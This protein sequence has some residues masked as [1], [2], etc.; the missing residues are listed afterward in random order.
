MKP[1]KYVYM[2]YGIGVHCSL[3]NICVK[4]KCFYLGSEL[5]G[6]SCKKCKTIK[7]E[8]SKDK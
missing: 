6:S 2:H 5:H 1:P 3:A 7:Y 8:R 4:N